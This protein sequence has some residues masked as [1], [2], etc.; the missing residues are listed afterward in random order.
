[1][2]LASPEAI[3]SGIKEIRENFHR[4]MFSKQRTIENLKRKVPAV[5]PLIPPSKT[6]SKAGE[7]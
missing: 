6:A 4:K 3:V 1:M 7:K 5:E 2:T